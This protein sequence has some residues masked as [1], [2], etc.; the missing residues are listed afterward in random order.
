MRIALQHTRREAN[1]LK[2]LGDALRILRRR[3]R[4][5]VDAQSFANEFLHCE[6]RIERRERILKDNLDAAAYVA[7]SV[8]GK[9]QNVLPS[10]EHLPPG[11]LFEPYKAVT[12]RR[13]PTAR[14]PHEAKGDT[15]RHGERHA[16]YCLHV[17]HHPLEKPLFH[18]EM[19]RE[20]PYLDERRSRGEGEPG[21][22]RAG[23]LRTEKAVL[24][25]RPCG[26]WVVWVVQIAGDP[27]PTRGGEEGRACNRAACGGIVAAFGKAATRHHVCGWAY[28]TSSSR[29]I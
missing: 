15:F 27:A 16:V 22:E 11:A 23:G 18:R 8:W 26:K 17:P 12:E 7:Q 19:R 10:K 3:E 1:F 4:G 20:V 13:L 14:F 6:A 28:S 25:H 5:F 9:R 21:R 24:R 29:E 2:H